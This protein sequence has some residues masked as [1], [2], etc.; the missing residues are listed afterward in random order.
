MG[1]SLSV[2]MGLSVTSQSTQGALPTYRRV[3]VTCDREQ[4]STVGATVPY[5]AYH[6]PN[7][8]HPLHLNGYPP[9]GFEH[10][11]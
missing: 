4:S 7:V 1:V 2:E 10:V 9:V 3:H 8:F 11:S 5:I 6:L